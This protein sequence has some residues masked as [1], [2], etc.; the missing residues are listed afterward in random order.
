MKEYLE[1]Y[2]KNRVRIGILIDAYE[3]QRIRRINADYTLS[4]N[5][6]M[7]SDDFREKL[8]LKGHVKDERGQYYVIN[9]RQR[10]RDGKKLT[11][12]ITCTHV[13]F[14][15]A[16]YKFPY[17]SYMSEGYGIQ[18]SQLTA[19]IAAATGGRFTISVDDTFDLADIKD[20]GNG[21]CLEALNAIISI[22]GAEVE[23]DNFT[24]HLRKKIGNTASDFHIQVGKNLITASFKDDG[25]SLCTRMY[26]E[27]KD[28]RTWIGQ[29]ASILT[30]DERGLLAQIPDAIVGGNLAVNYLVSP[31][32][33][34][35]GSDSVPYFDDIVREQS[36]TDVT[37]LLIATRK[38]LREREVPALEVTV[39]AADLYKVD[40]DEPKPGLGDT[41][42]CVD[43]EL[44]LADIS[45]RITEI[46]E[47]PY[48][49]DN[50]TQLTV[51]NV[52]TRDYTQIIAGLEVSRRAIDNVFSGGRIRAEA[53]EEFARL[54]VIDVNASKTEVKYDARGIVLQSKVI[55]SNQ[56]IMTAD[57][58]IFTKDGGATAMT[59]INANGIAAP[60]ITGQLG[61]FVSLLIG[62][63]NNVTQIN[64]NGIAAGHVTFSSAPA[65]IDMQGNA[66]FNKLTANSAQI[67]SSNLNASSWKDGYFSGNITAQGEIT[68]GTITGALLRTA[69][70]GARV[71]VDTRGW[72]TYDANNRQ[73]IAINREDSYGMSA[74]QWNKT[75]GALSG[76]INGNDSLFQILAQGDI[77]IAALGGNIYLQGNVDF[78]NA[79]AGGI[80]ISAIDNL[81][82]K[83]NAI[84]S[85]INSKPSSSQTATNM[86]FDS[87][88]RNLK[89]FSVSGDTLAM[90]NIPK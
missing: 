46:T 8:P 59:A 3:I 57:G 45:A 60:A 53:F 16:D 17:A 63:G 72:R 86:Q 14:K 33:A 69:A 15:L 43:P 48:V 65:R 67:N 87:S 62:S 68:G 71:E 22:Y 28:G 2:D 29:P 19:K 6:P 51:A 77:Q 66:V 49:S 12:A 85:S 18:I 61:S 39:S 76:S 24:I 20:F 80:K 40:G 13:M 31:Y 83:L 79:S 90:V 7:G 78:S 73:R 58:V 4:F 5:V 30:A 88:T 54:A 1:S 50:Q 81:Q 26:A 37:K 82:T 47:Y 42:T 64:P 75:S 9:G 56:V 84:D 21:N 34:Y 70:S 38:R 23:P 27:M 11:A 44:G 89:L 55:A 52:M 25:A 32:A 35:W 41:V 10:V 74:I 36:V